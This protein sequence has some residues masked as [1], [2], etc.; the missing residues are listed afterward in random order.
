[1][2]QNRRGYE[3][4][5]APKRVLLGLT[6]ILCIS[7]AVN[8]QV[9]LPASRT[10]NVKDV[11]NLY[12]VNSNLYRGG[13]PTEAGLRQLKKLGIKTIIDLRDDDG[14]AK[15]EENSAKAAG[16]RFINIPLSN[17]FGPKDEK[18]LAILNE[19][20]R[21]ENYP[22]FI[23]CK[24]GADRTGTVIA[25]YRIS[26]DG[27]TGEK[28]NAE[29]KKFGFGWWQFWMKDYINDYYRDFKIKTPK[30]HESPMLK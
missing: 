26:H 6:L 4:N 29:A 11:P 30:P 28:A 18:I 16:L 2:R 1:M 5:L 24:R 14:R 21:S 23:H 8:A 20:A 7:I 27:W 25:V 19:I 17:I 12:K 9:A 10:P 3:M 13:Q 15:R 22:V